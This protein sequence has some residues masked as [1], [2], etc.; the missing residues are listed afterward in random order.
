VRRI[1]LSLRRIS[2]APEGLRILIADDSPSIAKLVSTLLRHHGAEVEEAEDGGIACNLSAGRDYDLIFMDI[3]M[4]ILSGVQ[5]AQRIRIRNRARDR[6]H[7][8][9]HG[10]HSPRNATACS[11]SAST[12]V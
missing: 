2:C 4:P 12:I 8:R 6:R 10:N 9:T 5:A 3:N 11:A 7:R 1:R